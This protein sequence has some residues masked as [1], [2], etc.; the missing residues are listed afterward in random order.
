MQLHFADEEQDDDDDNDDDDEKEEE[1]ED[2]D[3]ED[4]SSATALGRKIDVT[5]QSN[6]GSLI[7]SFGTD[8]QRNVQV[9]DNKEV[10]NSA[11]IRYLAF[12]SSLDD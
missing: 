6:I 8:L 4:Y 5:L 9:C 10:N 1:E 7:Q 3:F 2:K 11:H 12:D